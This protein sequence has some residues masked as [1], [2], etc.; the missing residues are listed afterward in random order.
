MRPQKIAVI[1]TA[2]TLALSLVFALCGCGTVERVTR[3][4]DGTNIAAG[5]KIPGTDISMAVFDYVGGLNITVPSNR[6]VEIEHRVAES[7]TYFGVIHTGRDSYM[8][9]ETRLTEDLP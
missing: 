1:V 4:T 8:K 2:V 9:A 7:N 5:F 3:V 6:V